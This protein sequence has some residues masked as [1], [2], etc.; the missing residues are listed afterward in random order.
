MQSRPIFALSCLVT[1][2]AVV[3]L[4]AQALAPAPA[5]TAPAPDC[6]PP[7]TP[8]A[9]GQ[10]SYLVPQMSYT[11]QPVVTMQAVPT[12]TYGVV[13][14]PAPPAAVPYLV[15][16]YAAAPPAAI[17]GICPSLSDVE[18]ILKLLKAL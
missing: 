5:A 1:V 3:E 14:G 7:A 8:P 13:T 10:Q 9:A 15:P 17:P 4:R 12:V 6:N 2:I 16:P 18:S 11:M